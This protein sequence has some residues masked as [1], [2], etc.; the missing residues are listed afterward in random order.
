LPN[1]IQSNIFKDFLFQD[2][3][4]QFKVHFIFAKP[5]LFQDKQGLT[6]YYDWADSLYSDFMIKLLQALE[7]RFYQAGDYIYE[8]G[9]EVN[10]HIYVISRDPR[11]SLMSTGGYAVGFRAKQNN[12]FHVRLGP[13]TIIVGYENFYEKRAEFT[14][15]ALMHVDAYGLRKKD[16]KPILDEEPE[17][18]K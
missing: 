11:K 6:I 13:K 3:L 9:D 5:D 8:E 2:F 7:P 12:Y 1:S 15:K 16:I 17:L 18:K 14:Y 10:E 4:E